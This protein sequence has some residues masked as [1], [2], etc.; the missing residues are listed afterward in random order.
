MALQRL[1]HDSLQNA[2]I[3]RLRQVVN[4]TS[5]IASTAGS[6][7]SEGRHDHDFLYRNHLFFS[8]RRTRAAHP[9]ILRLVMTKSVRASS[10][11]CKG[12]FTQRLPK[13]VAFFSPTSSPGRRG[14][15][16]I[17]DDETCTVSHHGM[18]SLRVINRR[19][20]LRHHCRSTAGDTRYLN[21]AAMILHDAI[22]DGKT[23]SG[24]A[25]LGCVKGLK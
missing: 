2:Q 15:S 24:P 7:A 25:R 11:H 4:R 10:R 22:R 1:L 16:S 17:V 3:H 21:C 23:E 20:K 5:R 9:G 18:L 8:R 14:Y 12:F 19:G 13:L 6:S